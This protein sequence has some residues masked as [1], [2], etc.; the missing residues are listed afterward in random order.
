MAKAFHVAG[1][2]DLEKQ[3]ERL[4]RS[5]GK[6]IL[7]RVLRKEAEPM[8]ADMEANAPEDP[9]GQRTLKNS[10]GVGSRLSKRQARLHRKMFKSDRASVEMFVGAGA[11]PSAHQQEFG[12]S[13]HGAQP[14]ARPA[15]DKAKGSMLANVS[16][17]LWTAVEKSIKRATKAGTLIK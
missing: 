11:V 12:N 13:R 2:R 9:D 14:F 1:L 3:L 6:G 16:S 8:A 5:T 4:N 10:I 17:S 7:R 15:W